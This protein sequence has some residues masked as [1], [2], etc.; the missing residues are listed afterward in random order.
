MTPLLMH[1]FAHGDHFHGFGLRDQSLQPLLDPFLSVDHFYMSQPTFAPHPHAGF[2]AVTYL[3]DD[4]E[5]G[6]V[7]KDSLGHVLDIHPGSLHWTRAAGGVMHDEAPQ[8][9]GRVAHGMQIFVNLPAAHKH[10][11]PGIDHVVQA[12]MPEW[13][14]GDGRAR[15]VFGSYDGH[16]SPLVPLSQATL[17][18]LDFASGGVATLT[19][20][21][22]QQAFVLMAAGDVTIAGHNVT[23]DSGLA[24]EQADMVRTVAVQVLAAARI[25]LFLGTPIREPVVWGGPFVMTSVDDIHQARRDFAAGKMGRMG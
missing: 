2:S 21:A 8:V 1:A 24:F 20:P 17:V 4:S 11:A 10:D 13:Q 25:A 14:M 7:N 23:R 22:G 3:F 6:F 18:D 12:D 15:L 5:T 16:I 19:I 9:N